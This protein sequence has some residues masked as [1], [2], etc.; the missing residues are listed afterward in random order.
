MQLKDVRV[1]CGVAHLEP[2]NITLLGGNSVDNEL[3]D[4][5]FKQG[6]RQRLG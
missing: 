6:L 4:H 3:R 1:V 5:H 2:R